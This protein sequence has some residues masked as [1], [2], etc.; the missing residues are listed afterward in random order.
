MSCFLR[1]Y[2]LLKLSTILLPLL[3]NLLLLS[4]SSGRLLYTYAYTTSIDALNHQRITHGH[5]DN[6]YAS[7]KASI[8]NSPH[9]QYSRFD[10]A[11]SFIG[12][13]SEKKKEM[14]I[15]KPIKFALESYSFSNSRI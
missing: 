9:H 1:K 8:I 14:S 6:I 15:F 13:R 12:Q 7:F 10:S 5:Y 2:L 3:A 11:F 4:F